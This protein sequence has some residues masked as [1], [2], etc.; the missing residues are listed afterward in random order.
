MGKIIVE[1]GAQYAKLTADDH[2]A[3]VVDASDQPYTRLECSTDGRAVFGFK[4][5]GTCRNVHVPGKKKLKLLGVAQDV[6]RRQQQCELPLLQ[7]SSRQAPSAD[8]GLHFSLNTS[9]SHP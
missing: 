4:A 6:S 3:L 5:D 2:L 8:F 7:S 1:D 9:C